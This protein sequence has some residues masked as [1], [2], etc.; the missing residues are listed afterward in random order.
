MNVVYIPRR[1]VTSEWGGTETVILHTGM[2]LIQMG[3]KVAVLCPN[4][5]ADRDRETVEGVPVRRFGYFYPYLG[6]DDDARRQ[7]DLKGGNLFSFGLMRALKKCPDLDLI[8]LHTGKRLGG[9]GRHVARSRG[10]PYVITLHGG[11]YD[12]PEEEAMTWTEPTRGTLEWGKVL[13]LLFGSRRVLDDAAA[14]ICVSPGEQAEI[15]RRFPD[16]RVVHIPHGV[17]A[18]RFA[19]GDGAG[20]RKKHGISPDARVVLTVGRIDPQKDQRFAVRFLAEVTAEDPGTHLLLV[21]P[22]TNDTYMTVVEDEVRRMGLG[23]RVTIIKGLD[24]GSSDLV[25]AYHAA[26]VFL[27]SSAHEPFGIV[28]LE[29]WAAGLPVITGRVGGVPSFVEDGRDGLLFEPGDMHGCLDAWHTLSA[30]EAKAAQLAAS[31]RDKAV[32]RYSWDGAAQG[33]VDLYE[34]VIRENGGLK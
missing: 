4:A 6:L 10:I 18:G 5:L 27:L 14:I 21:G 8:H 33:I 17:D 29:A 22:V 28:V 15:A 7:L 34:E 11:V 13:G 24:A 32:G 12:V 9:I 30:D 1:F 25:D 19:E 2:R 3:H 23:R 20:F 16:K 31:G 26:D